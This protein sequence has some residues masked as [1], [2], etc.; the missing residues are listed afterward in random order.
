MDKNQNEIKKIMQVVNSLLVIINFLLSVINMIILAKSTLESD[1]SFILMLTTSL[2]LVFSFVF[3]ITGILVPDKDILFSAKAKRNLYILTLISSIIDRKRLLS[4]NSIRKTNSLRRHW[5]GSAIFAIGIPLFFM[6]FMSAGLIT[7]SKSWD[8]GYIF[9][10]YTGYTYG[11]IMTIQMII[12]ILLI[13]T[14]YIWQYNDLKNNTQVLNYMKNQRADNNRNADYNWNK[15][16]NQKSKI[17][18]SV[19]N[20]VFT[21]DIYNGICPACG[22]Y[23]RFSENSFDTQNAYK[24]KIAGLTVVKSFGFIVLITAAIAVVLL[25]D[26]GKINK[27]VFSNL[28][29]NPG[30]NQVSENKDIENIRMGDT[31]TLTFTADEIDELLG[32]I[33]ADNDGVNMLHREVYEDNV[34]DG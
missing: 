19:C 27:N 34:T 22:K 5:N 15:D 21:Y 26:N 8:L 12:W 13:F 18:C 28:I 24:R 32:D 11:L 29:V 10:G 31:D 3:M 9:F 6:F 23:N 14:A 30:L 7:N 17:Q 1:Q 16:Y 33:L 25:V 20:T 2:F 4:L